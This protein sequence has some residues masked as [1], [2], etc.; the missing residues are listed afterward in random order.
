M[1]GSSGPVGMI[2]RLLAEQAVDKVIVAIPD[3]GVS[4]MREAV[5]ECRRQK[6]PVKV[7]PRL[8][9]ILVGKRAFRLEDFSVEDFLLRRAPLCAD[10]SE[11]GESITGKRVLVTGAGGSIGSEVCRQIA[12]FDP[13]CLVL[14]GHGADDP[15]PQGSRQFGYY[16]PMSS[17]A[18]DVQVLHRIPRTSEKASA[19]IRPAVPPRN[20][21]SATIMSRERGCGGSLS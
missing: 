17:C 3:A 8:S 5:I 14:L 20:R 7:V 12:S 9:E 16:R 18:D 4:E 13:E 15:V 21:A 11:T 1:S 10:L 19:A 6:L 2:H